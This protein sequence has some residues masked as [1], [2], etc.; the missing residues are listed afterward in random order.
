MWAV[1]NIAGDC[2]AA[3]NDVLSTDIV[4]RILDILALDKITKN[5]LSLTYWT[6]S[7]LCRGKP[8]PPF[9]QVFCL[10]L[11]LSCVHF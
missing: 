9:E 10:L 11:T 3:R 1:G 8:D 6:I 4:S 2:V 5:F 7:H